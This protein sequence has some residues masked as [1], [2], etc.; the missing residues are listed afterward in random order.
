MTADLVGKTDDELF[1]LSARVSAE[2]KRRKA[3]NKL[4]VFVFDGEV[5]KSVDS[6]LKGLQREV[7]CAQLFKDGPEMYFRHAIEAGRR[8]TLL[9]LELDFWNEA[10]YAARP[11][12]VFVGKP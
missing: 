6:A 4:P 3:G 11:D 12:V 7:S 8:T 1:D 9:A 10:E 5:F 2:I